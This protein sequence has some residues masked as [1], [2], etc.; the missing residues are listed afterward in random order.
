MTRSHSTQTKKTYR[1]PVLLK[2][3]TVSKLTKGGK[4]GSTDFQGAGAQV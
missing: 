1:K 4:P 3:G 2:K